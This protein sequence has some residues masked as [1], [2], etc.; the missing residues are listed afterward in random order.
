MNT[1]VS[2]T[3]MQ[4]KAVAED[5]I[6]IANA[7]KAT[8]ADS[9]NA[10]VTTAQ[11]VPT[12]A[13]TVASPVFVH[14]TS[15]RADQVQAQQDVAKYSTLTLAWSDAGTSSGV[16]YVDSNNNSAKNDDEKAYVLLNKFYIKSSG[17]VIDPTNLLIND[18]VVTGADK[19]IEN[20]LRVLVV[21][22]D[23]T[24]TVAKTYAPVIDVD[25]GTTTLSYKWK[26]TDSVTALD[27]TDAEGF[28]LTTGITSIP[29]YTTAN[30]I[31]ADIYIYFE[32]EDA[33]C[34]SANIA[35]ITTNDLAVTVRFG[36][37]ALH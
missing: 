29:A 35:G 25:G 15:T 3:S 8:W 28:D 11:L 16:G 1:T 34:M 20:S 5:G 10:K 7:D 31:E 9:A 6:L 36:I 33:N 19:K 18:V 26:N 24:T 23:G 30:P 17:A 37:V 27:A 22:T 32:G 21:V 2:A 12:N 4:V 13:A 14:A